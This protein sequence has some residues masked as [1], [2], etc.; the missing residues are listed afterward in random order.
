MTLVLDMLY[1]GT[2]TTVLK[3]R[4]DY[5]LDGVPTELARSIS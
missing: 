3:L 5:Y 1:R 2:K 4:L